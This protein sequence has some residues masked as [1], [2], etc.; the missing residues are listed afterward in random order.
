MTKG[1]TS[2]GERRG[3]THMLCP[4]CGRHAYHVSKKVCGACAYPR[5]TRRRY[6]WS[7]KSAERKTTGTGRMRYLKIVQRKFKNGFRSGTVA[8][9]PAHRTPAAK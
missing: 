9:T 8:K 1:T 5:P 6:G 3:R 7:V 4:R 2:M